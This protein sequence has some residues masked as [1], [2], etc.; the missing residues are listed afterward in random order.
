MTG[1]R[2][3]LVLLLIVAQVPGCAALPLVA[4]PAKIG[5]TGLIVGSVAMTGGLIYRQR[6]GALDLPIGT[7]GARLL[8]AVPT[9]LLVAGV[10]GV[11]WLAPIVAASSFGGLLLSHAAHQRSGDDLDHEPAG[12]REETPLTS[13]LEPVFGPYD[14]AWPAERKELW[15]YAGMATIEVT[16][17]ALIVA[18]AL[19]F[20][21]S[22][23]WAILGGLFPAYF[24]GWRTPS[25]V[26]ELEQG[27]AASEFMTGVV[28]YLS[29]LLAGGV[30]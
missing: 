13:W 15:H 14:R 19:A 25:G 6:G 17:I 8:W 9:G 16:R 4:L 7:Q 24:I 2:R 18:P 28:V 30:P 27:T 29:I 20:D 10:A 23:A 3:W 26:P 22:L 21:P 11:W 1:V 5:T 12:Y